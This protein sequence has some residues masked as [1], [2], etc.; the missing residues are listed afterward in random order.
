MVCHEEFGILFVVSSWEP[1]D[2]VGQISSLFQAFYSGTALFGSV[3]EI[4]LSF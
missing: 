4:H 1:Q 2:I 3:F